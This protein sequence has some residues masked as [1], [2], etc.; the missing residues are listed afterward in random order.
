M[1]RRIVLLALIA[2]VG[3]SPVLQAMDGPADGASEN[4][5]GSSPVD[6]PKP[7]PTGDASGPAK[8]GP[9]L[10]RKGLDATL[11]SLTMKNGPR[12]VAGATG[13]ITFIMYSLLLNDVQKSKAVADQLTQIARWGNDFIGAGNSMTTT[14]ATLSKEAFAKRIDDA[15]AIVNATKSS[16]IGTGVTAPVLFGLLSLVAGYFSY[17]DTAT[18]DKKKYV[19]TVAGTFTTIMLSI[20]AGVRTGQLES[21][22]R[23][24]R[25]LRQAVLSYDPHM[26]FG[27][28]DPAK[29]RV[30]EELRKVVSS[31]TGAGMSNAMIAMT[32]IGGGV[33]TLTG[34][35]S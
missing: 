1:L 12:Y 25:I 35:R 4:P 31:A 15:L 30:Q 20:L 33:M 29:V 27:G 34:A 10:L 24:L 28:P 11:A 3:F 16:A 5:G 26:S 23:S 9:S 6:S 21:V 32:T 18:V 13:L 2:M 7:F 19:G 8:S 17:K 22:A 14:G